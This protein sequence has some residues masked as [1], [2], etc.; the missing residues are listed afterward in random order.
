MTQPTPTINLREIADSDLPVFFEHAQDPEANHM[1]A[2]TAKDP[3]DRAAF[4]AHWAK[5]RA[6][7]TVT[8]R[9]IVVDG[10][11]AGWVGSYGPPDEPE[12]TYWLGREF[13]GKGL[14]T[15]ALRQFLTSQTQRPIYGRAAAD[16]AA[17]LRVLEKCGFRRL[18]TERGFANARGEEI[19]EVRLV[20]VEP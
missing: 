7:P 14:A 3:S 13:W 2:F 8:Q 20:L 16:N 9:T 19:E 10:V 6:D 12:V 15:A 18:D 17:S 1:A 11:V 5:I 4:D